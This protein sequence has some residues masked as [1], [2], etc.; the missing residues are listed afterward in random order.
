LEGLAPAK[1]HYNLEVCEIV[2]Q[3][4][5][6]TWRDVLIATHEKDEDA[7]QTNLEFL[8]AHIASPAGMTAD[9]LR[10]MRETHAPEVD[11]LATLALQLD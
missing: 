3:A 7:E 1:A 11:E 9:V 5:T 4:R 6:Q 8:A 10:A 2:M